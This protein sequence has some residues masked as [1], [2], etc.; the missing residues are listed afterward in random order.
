M[1]ISDDAFLGSL[2]SSSICCCKTNG[3]RDVRSRRVLASVNGGLEPQ[4]GVHSQHVP[5]RA[6][7]VHMT[8][9]TWTYS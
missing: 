8:S 1:L 2:G 6:R 7:K 5:E 4:G 9:Y 3:A